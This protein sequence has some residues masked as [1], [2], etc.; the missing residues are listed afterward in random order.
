M[1]SQIKAVIIFLIEYK[2]FI[3]VILIKFWIN[4]WYMLINIKQYIQKIFIMFL[5]IVKVWPH[6]ER[7]TGT[8]CWIFCFLYVRNFLNNFFFYFAQEISSG[9]NH[10]YQF[11][12]T[13]NKMCW[14]KLTLSVKQCKALRD[15]EKFSILRL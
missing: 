15:L 5:F 1:V 7:T 4:E 3:S 11:E 6:V 13:K 10:K 2:N 12:L 8:I 9:Y 14:F